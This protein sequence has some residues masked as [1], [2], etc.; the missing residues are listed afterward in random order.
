MQ[1]V[2]EGA[3]TALRDEMLVKYP[4]FCACA[5][6]RDDALTFALN[7]VRPRYI[8]GNRALGTALTNAELAQDQLRAELTVAIFEGLRRVANNPRHGPEG[9]VSAAETPG[10]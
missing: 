4:R 6:C 9:K 10:A 7:H 5:Q 1:N 3:L 8:T 2:L